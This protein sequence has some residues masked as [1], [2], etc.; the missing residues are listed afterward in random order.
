MIVDRGNKRQGNR[1]TGALEETGNEWQVN[2][3]IEDKGNRRQSNRR[4]RALEET[5]NKWTREPV[6]CRQ[7]K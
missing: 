7:G 3:L 6:N 4:T 5:G 1:R 2:Q